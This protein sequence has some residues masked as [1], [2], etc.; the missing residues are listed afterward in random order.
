[1]KLRFYI[2]TLLVCGGSLSGCARSSI[3]PPLSPDA[4]PRTTNAGEPGTAS[5][6]PDERNSVEAGGVPGSEPVPPLSVPTLCAPSE[7]ALF[8]CAIENT[9]KAVVICA[10]RDAAETKGYLY[11]AYGSPGQMELTYPADKSPPMD[12]FKRTHLTFAGNTGGYAYSFVNAGIKYIVYSVSGTDALEEHGVMVMG[13]D[14]RTPLA[15][16]DCR[17]DTVIES[18]DEDLVNLTIGW[19]EDTTIARQ[20]LPRRN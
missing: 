17:E 5:D 19:K 6:F 16:H 7:R 18:E 3:S 14:S 15:M 9:Q 1:M 13:D 20:G 12:R 2:A 11:Y 8:S 4:R 10:S